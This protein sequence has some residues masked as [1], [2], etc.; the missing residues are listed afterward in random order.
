MQRRH[1]AKWHMEI[2]ISKR[3]NEITR[4]EL[5]LA[6]PKA[7]KKKIAAL[8]SECRAERDAYKEYVT[9]HKLTREF[10]IPYIKGE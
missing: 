2:E 8:K 5:Y 3:V 9:K 6:S 4:Y 7:L 1:E 10:N